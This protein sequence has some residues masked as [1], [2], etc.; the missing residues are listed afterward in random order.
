MNYFLD[1][2]KEINTI[3]QKFSS[4]EFSFGDEKNDFGNVISIMQ[5]TIAERDAVISLLLNMDDEEIV[6]SISYLY[7]SALNNAV[8][9]NDLFKMSAFKFIAYEIVLYTLTNL[10]LLDK[11]N[12]IHTIISKKYFALNYSQVEEVSFYYAFGIRMEH[13]CNIKKMGVDSEDNR[14]VTKL[15]E[16]RLNQDLVSLSDLKSCDLLINDCAVLAGDDYI[17]FFISSNT[18][19][20]L[21]MIICKRIANDESDVFPLYGLNNKNE[22]KQRLT[23][24]G[25]IVVYKRMRIISHFIN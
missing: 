13:A 22:L 15:I 24:L 20:A 12:L 10:L 2:K 17:P 23:D 8:F 3:I 5:S 4:N 6:A 9:I 21:A 19:V 7:N 18:G 14:A 1:F 25:Q 16:N 11:F